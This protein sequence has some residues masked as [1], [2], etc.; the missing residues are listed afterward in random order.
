MRDRFEY[1]IV[2]QLVH[3]RVRT[4]QKRV[5]LLMNQLQSLDETRVSVLLSWRLLYGQAVSETEFLQEIKKLPLQPVLREL[6]SVLQYG[7]ANEPSAYGALDGRI[8]EFFGSETANSITGW[9]SK[10]K[11]WV[12]FSQW[13][14]LFAIKLICIFG[15]RNVNNMVVTY[16]Q[17]LKLLLMTN[18]F[19][20]SL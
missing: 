20:G 12:F 10:G 8:T 11:P 1:R 13:Q 3:W 7:D 6:I 16:D 5:N 9:L 2:G 18:E 17:F 4:S 14:L 19:Y 15:S